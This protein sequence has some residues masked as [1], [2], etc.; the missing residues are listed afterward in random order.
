MKLRQHTKNSAET[1]GRKTVEHSCNLGEVRGSSPLARSF[2]ASKR[3]RWQ[4]V[5]GQRLGDPTC[6]Y[7]IRWVWSTPFGSLRLHHWLSSDDARNFHD[8]P[9]WFVTFVLRGGYVDVSPAG[10][11]RCAAGRVCYRPALHQHT[12]RVDAGGCWTFLITGPE[13]RFWGFW[14]KSK[15]KKANKYFLEHGHHPC[16]N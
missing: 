14:V 3:W 6:P 15:F 13:H 11:D 12:V 8:H 5:L 10:E 2:P 1:G 16:A 9:W 4:L 7:L